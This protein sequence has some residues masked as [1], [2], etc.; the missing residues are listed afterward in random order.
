MD[1][2]TA[3]VNGIL[4]EEVYVGQPLVATGSAALVVLVVT[5]GC[6]VDVSVTAAVVAVDGEVDDG[7]A[8]KVDSFGGRGEDGSEGVV[9]VDRGDAGW[10]GS[11]C[12][13]GGG[14]QRLMV[15]LHV[16]DL[17]DRATMSILGFAGKSR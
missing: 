8:A 14:R 15:V 6:V 3:F 13:Q 4:K 9:A 7:G 16:V 12:C 10:G 1:V 11:G 5:V 17:I 2:K